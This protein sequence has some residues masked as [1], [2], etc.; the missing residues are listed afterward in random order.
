MEALLGEV[1]YGQVRLEDS[2]KELRAQNQILL[3][4]L[5]IETELKGV[6]GAAGG[7]TFAFNN[8][9]SASKIKDS[10]NRGYQNIGKDKDEVAT[11]PLKLVRP[12]SNGSNIDLDQIEKELY[13]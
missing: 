7:G 3:K 6:S 5:G 10:R 13:M 1:E 8:I 11:A 2:L 12:Q 4:A 9:K